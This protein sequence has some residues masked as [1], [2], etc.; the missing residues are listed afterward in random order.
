MKGVVLIVLRR[1]LRRPRG[2]VYGFFF[3]VSP[4][5]YINLLANPNLD[6]A[7]FRPTSS[8]DHRRN[9]TRVNPNDGIAVSVSLSASIPFATGFLYTA[10]D[11]NQIPTIQTPDVH[12]MR[13]GRS[14]ERWWFGGSAR[15]KH[16]F[17]SKTYVVIFAPAEHQL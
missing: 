12:L 15:R 6:A 3:N 9:F 1:V 13:S 5:S 8:H 14:S 7:I 2:D 17:N 4:R 10:E 16:A 11:A